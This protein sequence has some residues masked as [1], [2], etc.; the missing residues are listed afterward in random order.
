MATSRS[1]EAMTKHQVAFSLVLFS[2][3]YLIGTNEEEE[4]DG[5]AA[6]I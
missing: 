3:H 2:D 4:R 1:Q 6:L 5:P